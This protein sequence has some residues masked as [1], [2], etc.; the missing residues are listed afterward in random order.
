MRPEERIISKAREIEIETAAKLATQAL[1][2]EE[3]STKL[4]SS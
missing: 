4:V 3:R 1:E 2:G